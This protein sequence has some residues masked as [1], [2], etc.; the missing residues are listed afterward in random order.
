MFYQTAG[1]FCKQAVF[2]LFSQNYYFLQTILY[3]S[4][5]VT[6]KIIMLR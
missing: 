1:L 6:N 4:K 5:T 3:M 2:L